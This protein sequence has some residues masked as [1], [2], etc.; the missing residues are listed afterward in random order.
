MYAKHIDNK[1]IYHE[2]KK[3]ETIS[4]ILEQY[5]NTSIDTIKCLNPIV[6]SEIRPGMYLKIL[7]LDA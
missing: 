1:Y 6:P 7:P 5:P 2:V 4:T 3:G